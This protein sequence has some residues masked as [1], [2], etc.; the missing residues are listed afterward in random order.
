MRKLILTAIVPL[1]LTACA[2]LD[3]DKQV[4]HEKGAPAM[5]TGQQMAMMQNNMLSMHEQMH[6]IMEA[7][8]PAERARLMRERQETMQ[9]L[10][11]MMGTHGMGGMMG[12]PEGG[13]Q[14]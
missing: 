1:A 5:N 6:R 7:K 8:D 10:M 9:Q 13:R 14:Q 3:D 4:H 2:A 11:K 12:G